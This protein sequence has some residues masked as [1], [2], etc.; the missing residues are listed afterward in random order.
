[1]H[2]DTAP[3]APL[4]ASTA[5]A[6]AHAQHYH[7]TAARAPPPAGP[8]GLG[9]VAI[10]GLLAC[11][12]L[13]YD[14]SRAVDLR[15]RGAAV[16]SALQDALSSVEARRCRRLLAPLLFC[17][18]GGPRLAAA[19]AD[20]RLLA[21]LCFCPRAARPCTLLGAAGLPASRIT[22][23]QPASQLSG[24][25]FPPLACSRVTPPQSGPIRAAPSWQLQGSCA[26][27]PP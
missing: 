3:I 18:R 6:A 13:R 10:P 4:P 11:L 2:S 26:S 23:P 1:M 9:D 8:P 22:R 25:L 5:A 14:A 7:L 20:R 21:W 15:A 27:G 19:Q 24:I 17:R 12:A 16:A